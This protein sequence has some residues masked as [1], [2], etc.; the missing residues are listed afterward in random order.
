MDKY[1]AT[2][3]GV[4]L[5]A[6]TA[7][8][9]LNLATP[10]SIRAR[11]TGI[12]VSFDGVTAGNVPALVELLRQTNAGTTTSVTPV[13]FDP[14]APSSLCTAGKNASVEPTG[15]T[16]IR[17][18]RVSPNGGVLIVPLLGADMVTMPVSG[19]LGIR[20]TAA[21]VVNVNAEISFLA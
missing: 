6:A 16:V 4:A 19:F 1:S 13:A 3:D 14:A 21:Q 7:K 10:A 20:C 15:T 9:V 2:A 17:S 8:T 18:W 5:V 11:I 12:Q